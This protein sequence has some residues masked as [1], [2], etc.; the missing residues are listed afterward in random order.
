VCTHHIHDLRNLQPLQPRGEPGMDADR[1]Y[2]ACGDFLL[3]RNLRHLR[4]VRPQ[5]GLGFDVAR[6][7]GPCLLRGDVPPGRHRGACNGR[8][9]T[10][11]DGLRRQAPSDDR[12][13]EERAATSGITGGM[14]LSQR[15]DGEIC[16]PADIR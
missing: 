14:F 3:R 8:D 11:G 2:A 1:R 10:A 4:A 12:P 7:A 15:L 9:R 5:L 6:R 13:A 16:S